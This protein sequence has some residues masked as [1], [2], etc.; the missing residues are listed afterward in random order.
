MIRAELLFA[1]IPDRNSLPQDSMKYRSNVVYHT[2]AY[3]ELCAVFT[4]SCAL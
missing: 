2:T 1:S 4:F 3:G